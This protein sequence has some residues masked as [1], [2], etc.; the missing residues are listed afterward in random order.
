MKKTDRENFNEWYV[1]TLKQMYPRRESGIAVLMLSIPLLE[2]YLRQKNQLSPSDNLNDA[3]MK[4]LCAMFV[5]LTSEAVA[6]QF[7]SVY[8]NGFLHQATLSLQTRGGKNLP[9]GVLSHDLTDAVA[10]DGKKFLVHPVLFS[11]CVIRE[12]EQNFSVFSKSVAAPLPTVSQ[13]K[14]FQSGVTHPYE[15]TSAALV[16][17]KP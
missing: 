5:A 11:Q 17:K 13:Y 6:W 12:I 10:V 1:D 14:L 7:W 8:R 15:G 4:D 16:P 3:F 9:V 2:R